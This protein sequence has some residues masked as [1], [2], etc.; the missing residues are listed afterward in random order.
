MET[1]RQPKGTPSRLGTPAVHCPCQVPW[2]CPTPSW[3]SGSS[4][5]AIPALPALLIVCE[6]VC[7]PH[8]LPLCFVTPFTPLPLIREAR[9]TET[10]MIM[11]TLCPLY[12]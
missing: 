3:D 2:A 1:A 12:L 6:C 10:Y 9:G 4:P 5:T 7:V 8:S 11:N